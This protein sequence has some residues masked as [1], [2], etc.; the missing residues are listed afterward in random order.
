L[1]SC[2]VCKVYQ[3]YKVHQVRQVYQVYKVFKVILLRP[4]ER[5]YGRT[6]KV[7]QVL[8]LLTNNL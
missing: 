5:D 7:R 2:K 6:S 8:M 4:V 1:F 3:V